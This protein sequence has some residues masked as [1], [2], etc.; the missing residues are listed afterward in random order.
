MQLLSLVATAQ[1]ERPMCE[2][3]ELA[4]ILQE[5]RLSFNANVS[6]NGRAVDDRQCLL[7]RIYSG[8]NAATV[9]GVGLIEPCDIR[10]VV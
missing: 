5:I 7:C 8:S 1:N 9:H 2:P 6:I 4:D 3:V 10:Q